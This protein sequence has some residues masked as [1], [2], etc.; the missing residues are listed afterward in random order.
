MPPTA[1]RILVIEDEEAIRNSMAYA[2]KSA[3]YEVSEAACAQEGLTHGRQQHCDLIIVNLMLPDLSGIEVIR[4]I[5]AD[6]TQA[7]IL[8]VTARAD[9]QTRDLAL[10]VG[11]DS[12]L[13]K[14]FYLND[15]LQRAQSLITR[16]T[17]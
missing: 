5:R 7:D 17:A 9:D 15:L 4:R 11:A 14:P 13:T 1:A 10:S 16:D 2:F 12:V 3:G 8:A 6:S